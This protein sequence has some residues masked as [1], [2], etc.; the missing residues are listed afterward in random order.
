VTACSVCIPRGDDLPH[1]SEIGWLCCWRARA[2]MESGLRALPALCDEL[3]GGGYVMRDG[4]TPRVLYPPGHDLAAQSVP[5]FDPIAN[6]LT[7]G[8]LNGSKGA[9]RVSGSTD[10]PV[11][12]R[13]DPTDLL[14]PAR[15]GSLAVADTGRYASDQIGHLAVATELEFWARDWADTLGHHVPLPTVHMLTEWLIN[16]L[17]WA[18]AEH[19]A[20]DEF[21]GKVAG[22][23]TALEGALGLFEAPLVVMD[24]P[25]TQCGTKALMLETDSD[26]IV[27]DHCGRALTEDE[28]AAELRGELEEYRSSLRASSW[29]GAIAVSRVWAERTGRKY[30]VSRNG[31]GWRIARTGKPVERARETEP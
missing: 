23:R 20:L 3:A 16:R 29:S 1:E 24:R 26:L 8:P 14:A 30:R 17:D 27:C 11:P 22:L 12:I 6:V 15:P 21:A 25:C 2:R 10:R 4:H 18:C 28:Y 7:A 13:I 31:S 5:H 9:P 19:A